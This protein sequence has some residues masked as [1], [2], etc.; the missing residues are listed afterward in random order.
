MLAWRV[1]SAAPTSDDRDAADP[2]RRAV[3]RPP[4]DPGLDV[5]RG[6]AVLLVL[7]RHFDTPP[8]ELMHPVRAVVMWLNRVGWIGVD[9]FF[10]LSGFLVS[11]L[12]FEEYERHGTL[13]VGRFLVRRGFKIYPGFY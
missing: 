2:P 11:G 5:L 12:L 1:G 10:V 6:V 13:R 7:F 4:R 8:E 9:L 3:T